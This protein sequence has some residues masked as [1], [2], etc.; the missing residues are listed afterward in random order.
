MPKFAIQD[1][2]QARAKGY[3]LIVDSRSRRL[4]V[5][6][7]TRNWGWTGRWSWQDDTTEFFLIWRELTFNRNLALLRG[8]IIDE[9]NRLMARLGIECVL[10]LAQPADDQSIERTMTRLKKA[11]CDFATA[12]K[13]VGLR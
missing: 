9:L 4:L 2:G 1:F 3:D 13:E 8:H 6:R 12:M 5:A 7:K 11:E 10:N